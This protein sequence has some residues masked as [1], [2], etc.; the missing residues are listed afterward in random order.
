M[1]VSTAAGLSQSKKLPSLNVANCYSFPLNALTDAALSLQVYPDSQQLQG[2]RLK[3]FLNSSFS[4]SQNQ[5]KKKIQG[6]GTL[7]FLI[8]YS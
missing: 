1:I 5:L 7:D 4:P 2:S 3:H 6:E 8:Q